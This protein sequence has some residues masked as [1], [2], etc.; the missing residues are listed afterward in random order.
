VII[1]KD[2][3]TLVGARATA[4]RRSKARIAEIRGQ[5]REA[6]DQDE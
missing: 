5:H 1:D 3:C 2:T 4:R 6:R